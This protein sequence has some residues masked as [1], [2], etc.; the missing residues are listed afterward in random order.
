VRF[1]VDAQLPPALARHLAVLGHEAVHV[2]DVGLL[3][4]RGSRDLAACDGH[5][6]CID[7]QG[8]VPL[9][10]ADPAFRSLGIG[11]LW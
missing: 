7:H 11:V 10:T 1:L 2:A 8:R 3:R 9:V 4:A 5:A 6:G